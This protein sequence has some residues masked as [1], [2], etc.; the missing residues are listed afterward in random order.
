MWNDSYPFSF[1][2]EDIMGKEFADVED[3]L[4]RVVRQISSSD[5]IKGKDSNSN[6]Y[7]HYYGYQITVGP[8]GKPRVREFG[9]IRPSAR[10]LI[11]QSGVRAPLVDTNLDEKENTLTITAEMP[12]GTKQ[13]IKVNI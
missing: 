11:E 13:D 7:P 8:D 4:N 2:V 5:L 12:G 3:M 10:G 1:W 9:N 6:N